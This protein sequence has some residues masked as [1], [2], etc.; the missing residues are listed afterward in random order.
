[1]TNFEE[2]I[3]LGLPNE[4]DMLERFFQL[5]RELDPDLILGWNLINFDLKVIRKRCQKLEVPFVLGRLDTV[6][7]LVLKEGFFE[8][9]K[10]IADGRQIIDL[11]MWV[12]DTVKL[13][14]YKWSSYLAY[15][16][17]TPKI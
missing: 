10:V 16:I 2:Q 1:M 12:R 14:D 4:K 17:M 15:I 6:T 3:K 5:V 11:L 8:R 7:K 9:S 13:E